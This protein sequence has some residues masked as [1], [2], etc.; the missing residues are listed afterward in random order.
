MKRLFTLLLLVGF[1]ATVGCNQA[2]GKSPKSG[3]ND[4]TP[5]S[6]SSNPANSGSPGK[7]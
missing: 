2:T 1:V 6:A 5:V 4:K 7:K 3:V